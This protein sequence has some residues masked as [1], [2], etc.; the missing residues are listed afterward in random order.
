M[1]KKVALQL[2]FHTRSLRNERLKFVVNY[3]VNQFLRLCQKQSSTTHSLFLELSNNV[4]VE[5][6]R[7][8]RVKILY[9][10][11]ISKVKEELSCSNCSDALVIFLICSFIHVFFSKMYEFDLRG[12]KAFYY[13]IIVQGVL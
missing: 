13:F 7:G 4:M 6:P 1:L 2:D 9:Q 11:T 8:P 12:I 3:I 5:S 10:T